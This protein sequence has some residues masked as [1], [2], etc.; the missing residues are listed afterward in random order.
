MGWKPGSGIPQV[1][2]LT[3]QGQIKGIKVVTQAEYDALPSTKNADGI[4]YLIRG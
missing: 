4:L 1:K 2:E 3:N